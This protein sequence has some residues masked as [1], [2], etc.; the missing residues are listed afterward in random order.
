[1]PPKKRKNVGGGKEDQTISG[2]SSSLEKA[3]M[4]A[5]QEPG[6]PRK[7]SL[8]YGG[9]IYEEHKQPVYALS[10]FEPLPDPAA[11][12]G[13][14]KPQF[15]A[16]VGS[17]RA[18]VYKIESDGSLSVA[19]AYVDEDPEEILYA[20]CWTTTVANTPLLLLGGFR[21]LIK[22]VDCQNGQIPA[23]LVGHG[24]AVNELKT[25]PVSPALVLSASKDESVRLWNVYTSC[26]IA[27]F[28]GDQGHRDEVLSAD[29]HLLGHCFASAGM[30]NTVK[31][32]SLEGQGPSR[33][34]A[35][36]IEASFSYSTSG[37]QVETNCPMPFHA[38]L[39]LC[40]R[41]HSPRPT[42]G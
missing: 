16:S 2:P 40:S 31:V 37:P 19:Q 26:C 22:M 7:L 1:M 39:T 15:F 38:D 5:L 42:A 3:H 8:R 23:T 21:G 6:G 10:F 12:G 4:R 24:N 33:R 17:N 28:A 14:P 9:C 20:L 25:H 41:P 18:T 36:N 34:I 30:D 29:M 32:W 35:Q 13:A 11:V 27:I